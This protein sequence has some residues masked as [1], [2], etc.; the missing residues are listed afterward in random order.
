M[1]FKGLGLGFEGRE[2]PEQR[3]RRATRIFEE[4]V[5][6]KSLEFMRC[7]LKAPTQFPYNEGTISF[8]DYS[9]GYLAQKEGGA[10]LIFEHIYRFKDLGDYTAWSI[11]HTFNALGNL[12]EGMAFLDEHKESFKD[13]RGAGTL[14]AD[15]LAVLFE[16]AGITVPE[17]TEEDEAG[18]DDGDDEIGLVYVGPPVDQP[19]QL[20]NHPVFGENSEEYESYDIGRWDMIT[21]LFDGGY[22]DY[23][24]LDNDES[25]K[26]LKRIGLSLEPKT[27]DKIN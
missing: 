18:D 22:F 12:G 11:L 17:V 10:E 1:I 8:S 4:H 5:K 25:R 27:T 7:E 24:L 13:A 20:A 16:P 3:Q 2:T 19:K 9:A 26:I 14:G 21:S 15:T 6:T 23:Q